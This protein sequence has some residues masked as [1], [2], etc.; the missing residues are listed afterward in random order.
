MGACVVLLHVL[1]GSTHHDWL[2]ERQPGGPLA[3]FRTPDRPD[4]LPASFR[5]ARL[6]DHR[7]IYLTYEGPVSGG[8]GTV[9][10]LAAGEARLLGSE[11]GILRVELEFLGVR[12][13][14]E[15]RSENGD[16]WVFTAA[17]PAR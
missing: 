14:Y 7:S 17:E 3:A 13:T 12:R 9:R 10:R 1:P 11:P 8:R 15:G 6:P 2:F 16:D 5:A 4:S